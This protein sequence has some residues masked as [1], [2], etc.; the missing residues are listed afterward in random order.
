M[1]E[2]PEFPH[3]PGGDVSNAVP[4]MPPSPVD[5]E[6]RCLSP[7]LQSWHLCTAFRCPVGMEG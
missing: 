3:I 4:D 2:D 5:E 7:G 6:A 1:D